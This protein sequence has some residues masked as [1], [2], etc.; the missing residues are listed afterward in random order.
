MI[1]DGGKRMGCEV[2]KEHVTGSTGFF[3]RG[4]LLV[5]DFVEGGDDRGITTAG[6]VKELATNL[7]DPVCTLLVQ[8]WRGGGGDKLGFLTIDGDCPGMR[9]ILRFGGSRVLES[10]E[11]LG[12]V[13]RHREVD[14]ALVIVPVELETKVLGA[15]PILGE[16]IFGGKGGKEVIG[17]VFA[18]IF[19]AKVVNG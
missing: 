17:I 10:A 14:V 12:D 16:L 8:G 2:V 15:G 9:G 13:T 7:L 18:E 4:G 5:G 19:D 6:I 1:A 11:S 3:G